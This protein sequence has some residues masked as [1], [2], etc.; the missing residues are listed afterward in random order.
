M[1][2][3]Y[4]AETVGE[5]GDKA[6][7]FV[8][9]CQPPT[10]GHYKVIDAMKAFIRDNPDLKLSIHPVVVIVAGEKTSTDKT[11]NP[12]TAEDR[13][14]FMESS[15][16]ANGVKF[17]TAN[18]G[19]QAWEEV[20]KAGFEPIAIAAGSDRAP[21]Y[22]KLLDKYFTKPD[23]SPIKHMV[24][25]G[26]ARDQDE[27]V[28]SGDE[29][30]DMIIRMINDGDVVDDAQI[31]GS[32]ARYTARKGEAKAFAYVV[33]LEKKPKLAALLMKKIATPEAD[34]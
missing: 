3:L 8:G 31:S 32:L 12:L 26:L 5:Q 6:V 18:N 17:L 34:K 11:Q 16:E 14:S 4:E 13:K 10:R 1:L 20:R 27:E 24:V 30:F 2:E 33:G 28:S 19:F 21:G 9:R 22:L 25:P 7:V 15:G 23:K 29:A